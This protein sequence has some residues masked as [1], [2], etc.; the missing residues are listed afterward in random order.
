[1]HLFTEKYMQSDNLF[2]I[3]LIGRT[4]VGKSTLFNR[5]VR[6]KNA[7]TYNRP[8]VTRDTKEKVI[9]IFDEYITLIDTPGMFDYSECDNK[10]ELMDAI[11]KKLTDVVDTSD[12]I[13]FVTDGIVGLTSNDI[14]IAS[15]LRK[16]GKKTIMAV[17]KTEG[18]VKDQAYTDA[19]A[20]GF[21]DTCVISAEHGFGIDD[22]LTCIYKYIPKQG[23]VN[24][25]TE[26]RSFVKLAFIGRP[27]VG[28][29]TL[30]NSLIG[31]DKQ[32]V[33]DFPGLTRESSAFD[34]VYK[35]KNFVLIDTPGVRR[36]ARINDQLEKISVS[37]TLR[38]YRHADVV[39]LIIDAT[40]IENGSIE[41]QDLTL[42]SNVLKDGRALILAFNKCDKTSF[43][44]NSKPKELIYNIQ[45][46]LAQ[47]KDVPFIFISA[48]NKDNLNELID[49]VWKTYNRH[50]IKINTPKLNRWLQA[51]NSTDVMK[52]A[53]MSFKPKY[54]TQ[55]GETPPT[56]LIFVS[57]LKEMR[58]DQKR[59]I[60]N[61]FKQRFN[62]NDVVVKLIFKS[63][64]KKHA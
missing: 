33:A 7:L 39:V 28:K 12:L 35:G 8:G 22:L 30:T 34:F 62:L 11:N 38:A 16:S 60:Q 50:K 19:V 18:R 14:N 27:N 47:H 57:K 26:Q 4:N 63:T 9:M 61:H 2:R 1:M 10:P 64:N 20:L 42:A 21:K 29:S 36:K 13:V 52:S 41:K 54:I 40:T 45:H 59:F 55:I 6:A 25:K 44:K 32:L 48:L 37:S 56:F 5:L 53:S 58:N 15:I 31:V 51:I 23:C 43:K 46:A 49:L 24:D 17:N 3:A